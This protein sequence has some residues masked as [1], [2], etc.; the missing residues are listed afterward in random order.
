M[1]FNKK[2]FIEKNNEF[3]YSKLLD[4]LES[5]IREKSYRVMLKQLM[6]KE[7][8]INYEGNQY[9]ITRQKDSETVMVIDEVSE[10]HGVDTSCTRFTLGVDE[11]TELITD[12]INN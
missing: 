10:E 6:S 3:L 12:Y 9:L 5:E 1:K 2:E 7:K 11:L 8:D 4:F